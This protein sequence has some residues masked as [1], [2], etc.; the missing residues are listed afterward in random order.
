MLAGQRDRIA[1]RGIAPDSC[2]SEVERETAE[3]ADFD[4]FTMTERFAHH[5]QQRLH[6]Q[7]DIIGLRDCRWVRLSMSSD[8]VIH[9]AVRRLS[10]DFEAVLLYDA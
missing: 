6:C 9:A 5:L 8:M 7:V 10:E 3:T 2:W 1:G 4:A